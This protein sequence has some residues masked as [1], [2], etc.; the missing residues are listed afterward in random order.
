MD[1][2]IAKLHQAPAKQGW[3]GFISSLSNH[4]PPNHPEKFIS[5]PSRQLVSS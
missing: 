1:P 4:N 2:E 3:V 5:Q